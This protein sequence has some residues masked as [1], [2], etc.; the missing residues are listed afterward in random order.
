MA[1]ESSA[2][3]TV[4]ILFNERDGEVVTSRINWSLFTQSLC[5]ELTILGDIVLLLIAYNYPV[6]C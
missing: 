2:L 6:Y 3:K 4:K 1:M 5:Y